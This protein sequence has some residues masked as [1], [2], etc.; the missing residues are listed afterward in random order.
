MKYLW[1]HWYL[2]LLK[3]Y[4]CLLKSRL[5]LLPQTRFRVTTEIYASTARPGK[6]AQ[7]QRE[8]LVWIY[9]I[10]NR[11]AG[12]G[13]FYITSLGGHSIWTQLKN[14][15]RCNPILPEKIPK[16]TLCGRMKACTILGC[17][18]EYFWRYSHSNF[19]FYM[20]FLPTLKHT[21]FTLYTS[22]GL[23]YWVTETKSWYQNC[24]NFFII[25]TREW[26]SIYLRMT[27]GAYQG[28]LYSLQE[29][30]ISRECPSTVY[31]RLGTK[32]SA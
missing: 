6:S 29:A 4:R 10:I 14:S 18:S 27:S 23:I 15:R 11:Q 24:S 32:T 3:F 12:Y 28:H 8:C 7:I 2:F 31:L 30:D 13:A 9:R 20:P 26:G 19:G 5:W 1:W 21:I 17:N 22:T 16:M 25:S